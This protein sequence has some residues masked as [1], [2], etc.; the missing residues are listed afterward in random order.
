MNDKNEIL[1]YLSEDYIKFKEA[2]EIKHKFKLDYLNLE[3]RY[4]YQKSSF[5]REMQKEKERLLTEL[6]K[7]TLFF[8]GLMHHLEQKYG[9]LFEFDNF[10]SK[11]EEN[12]DLGLSKEF[13]LKMNIPELN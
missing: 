3:F 11:I 4:F 12:F 13:K 2:E 1:M 10:N 7:Y 9:F 6:A 5:T 8:E